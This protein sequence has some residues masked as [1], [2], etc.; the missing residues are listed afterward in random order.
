MNGFSH[1]ETIEHGDGAESPVLMAAALTGGCLC[2]ATRF[3]VSAFPRVHYCHCSMCR[4][5][6]GGAFAVLGWVP[7]DSLK[8]QVDKGRK[9]FRS[10][11]IALRSFCA[12]CGTPLTLDYDEDRREIAL[13]VGAFD[14]PATL[15]PLYHYGVEGRLAWA[16]THDG[17]PE[18]ASKEQW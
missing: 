8:W 11:P 3:S 6:T 13:H 10:S 16:D 17:L 15:T 7:R 1:D 2:G 4:K 14:D 5:A 9:I 18:T 12:A